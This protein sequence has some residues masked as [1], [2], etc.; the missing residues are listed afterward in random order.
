[1]HEWAL[2]EAV[3]VAAVKTAERE[4]LG[5]II[6]VTVRIGELQQIERETFEFALQEVLAT[7]TPEV[8]KTAFQLETDPAELACRACQHEWLLGDSLATLTHEEQEAIHF[9]PETVHVYVKC[10]E[11][12]SPDFE[13]VQGRGVSVASV[14]GASPNDA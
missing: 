12:R 3:V 10:P 1:M 9:L 2:A 11:C 7:Q 13:V 14:S 5:E 4:H 6:S 8:A